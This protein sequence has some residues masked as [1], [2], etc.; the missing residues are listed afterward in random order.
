MKHLIYIFIVVLGL[1]SCSNSKVVVTE[2]NMPEDIFYLDDEIKP[3]TGEAVI[4]FSN[5]EVVKEEL[6]YKDGILCGEIVSYYP[7]GEIKRKGEYYMGR[8]TG[9]W[10]CWYENGKKQ[11]EV[12]YNNDTL[13]G[14]YIAWYATG[15]IAKKG[16]FTGNVRSGMWMEYDE[17]G[18]LL[19]KQNY[20]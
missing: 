19:I 20:N 3:Y 2:A 7:N 17:A 11:Y 16:S 5:T 1:A 13:C 4:Y 10:E 9:K 6:T 12:E 18:M 8:L 15:V 14:A